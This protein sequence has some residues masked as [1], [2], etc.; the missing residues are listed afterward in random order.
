MKSTR[1]LKNRCFEVIFQVLW[2][3]SITICVRINTHSRQVREYQ[4]MDACKLNETV[5]NE[6][7]GSRKANKCAVEKTAIKYQY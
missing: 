3:T 1:L 6:R 2:R 5:G 4:Q 7:L